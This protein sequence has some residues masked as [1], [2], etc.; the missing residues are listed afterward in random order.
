MPNMESLGFRTRILRS[1]LALRHKGLVSIL[2]L[3]LIVC[4]GPLGYRYWGNSHLW[5]VG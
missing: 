4:N 2:I 5:L 3:N 1:M